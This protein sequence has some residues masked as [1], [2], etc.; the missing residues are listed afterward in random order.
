MS[1]LFTFVVLAN[2]MK[3]G[4]KRACR[5]LLS[6]SNEFYSS[7]SSLRVSLNVLTWFFEIFTFRASRLI[8]NGGVHAL[9]RET[10]LLFIHGLVR[11]SD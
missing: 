9:L 6:L 4:M 10:A 8:T 7:P 1:R 2:F 3:L 11:L 5:N